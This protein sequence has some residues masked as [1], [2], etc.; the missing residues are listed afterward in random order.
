MRL[1]AIPQGPS[2]ESRHPLPKYPQAVEVSRY[3]VVVEVALHDRLEPLSRLRHRVVHPLAELLLDWFQLG[4]HAFAYRLALHGEVPLL[5]LP[6]DV[7]EPQKIERLGLSFPSSFPVLFGEPPELDPARLI[8]M[9]FQPKLPQPLPEIFPKAVC[10]V[11][12]VE[13]ADHGLLDNLVFQRRDPQ[14]ALPPVS[15]REVHPS[16]W[17]HSIRPAVYPAV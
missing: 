6:A 4:S 17:L 7:R 8:W 3:R 1:A 13:N 9:K 15:F 12:L 2:P 5:G 16:R 11:N 10:F 14:R